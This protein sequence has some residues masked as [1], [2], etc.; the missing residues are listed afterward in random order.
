MGVPA[1]TAQAVRAED[2]FRTASRRMTRLVRPAIDLALHRGEDPLPVE[3]RHLPVPVEPADATAAHFHHIFAGATARHA[4]TSGGVMDADL[5]TRFT[6]GASSTLP[7]A[8]TTERP[9]SGR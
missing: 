7:P 9:G 2:V 5:F 6:P 4:P 3:Q 1:E 8:A